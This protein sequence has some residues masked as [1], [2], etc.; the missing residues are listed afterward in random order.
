MSLHFKC[1]I[2]KKT[3]CYPFH[4][5]FTDSCVYVI[6]RGNKIHILNW[7]LWN[8]VSSYMTIFHVYAVQQYVIKKSHWLEFRYSIPYLSNVICRQRWSYSELNCLTN[9][10]VNFF[11]LY[12]CP[13]VRRLDSGNLA[14]SHSR[15][16]LA[17]LVLGRCGWCHTQITAK[18][19]DQV[20][21]GSAMKMG[22]RS[23]MSAPSKSLKPPCGMSPL[24]AGKI[25]QDINI[26]S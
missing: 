16:Q 11:S 15:L 12:H 1:R 25:G 26:F 10:I 22:S 4:A 8:S 20:G 13:S 6:T 19:M 23:V 21:R 2:R 7:L 17:A 9:V 5:L 18:W 24:L 14:Q 3:F